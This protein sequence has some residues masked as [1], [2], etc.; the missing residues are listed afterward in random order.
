MNLYSFNTLNG[1]LAFPI[2][3]D[4]SGNDFGHCPEMVIHDE[5]R[6]WSEV[7]ESW[8]GI[9]LSMPM[10]ADGHMDLNPSLTGPKF[11]LFEQP[12]SLTRPRDDWFDRYYS[13]FIY[14][15]ERFRNLFR[16]SQWT[17][18]TNVDCV[19]H[20]IDQGSIKCGIRD[21][22][23]RNYLRSHCTPLPD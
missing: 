20:Y 3:G 7:N 18:S 11:L 15:P 9:S 23:S 8:P 19:D 22:S 6:M 13:S 1:K 10:F 17:L 4:L 5:I 21:K 2:P 14:F 12:I 16:S